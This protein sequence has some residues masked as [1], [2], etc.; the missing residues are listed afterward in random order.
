MI[1]EMREKFIEEFKKEF[2]LEDNFYRSI[3]SA[4]ML[5]LIY[6]IYITFDILN[7]EIGIKFIAIALL[8]QGIIV[9]GRIISLL[10][11]GILY[12]INKRKNM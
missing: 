7:V 1:K 4:S 6:I 3:A 9:V 2:N 8:V 5:A 11:S 10:I 12:L